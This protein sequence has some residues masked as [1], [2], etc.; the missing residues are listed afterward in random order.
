MLGDHHPDFHV[1]SKQFL[2]ENSKSF[3]KKVLDHP[4]VYYQSYATVMNSPISDLLLLVPYIIVRLIGGKNDG[5]V[6]V[7][8]AKW[9]DFKGVIKNKYHRGISHGDII[10]LK[11]E[12]Y[13]GFDV[14]EFYVQRVSELKTQG[15]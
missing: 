11:R 13:H 5:L 15:Y 9:G 6:T 3:N 2:K 8:S 7:E 14:R 10:D 1:A 12:D 4:D